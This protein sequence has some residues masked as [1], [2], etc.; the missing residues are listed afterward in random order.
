MMLFRCDIRAAVCW[1]GEIDL[2]A[3]PPARAAPVVQRPSS[4][5]A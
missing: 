2:Y 3:V 4:G 1:E 5:A